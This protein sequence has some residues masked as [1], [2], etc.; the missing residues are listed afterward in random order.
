MTRTLRRRW[1]ASLLAL[2]V[3]VAIATTYGP[4]PIGPYA[5]ANNVSG[6]SQM[7]QG[8][9]W[10]LANAFVK[11]FIQN[12]A[13]GIKPGDR[14]RILYDDGAIA[15][16]SMVY[17]GATNTP[18]GWKWVGSIALQFQ[19]WALPGQRASYDYDANMS[20]YLEQRIPTG[21]WGNATN[22]NSDGSVTVWGSWIFTGFVY[23]SGWMAC[24]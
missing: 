8:A 21:Y 23:T 17:A 3:G 24:R 12:L 9:E 13:P 5:S 14:V 16:F 1:Y 7:D 11:Q 19:K 15:E 18:Q 6:H 2:V 10:S 22:V 20:C 4:F